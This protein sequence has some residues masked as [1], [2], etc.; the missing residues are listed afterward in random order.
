MSVTTSANGKTQLEQ[1]VDE[2]TDSEWLEVHEASMN[3]GRI[4]SVVLISNKEDFPF[5][6]MHNLMPDNKYDK[7]QL[8]H[9]GRT[10]EEDGHRPWLRFVG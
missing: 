5:T 8:Y 9:A 10:T 3:G 1:L 2:Y 7:L 4:S 6:L